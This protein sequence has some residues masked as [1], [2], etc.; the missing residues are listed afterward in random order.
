MLVKRMTD[1]VAFEAVDG[2][3]IRELLH[4]AHGDR[5]VR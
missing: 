4:P 2:C 5:R 3:L 1:C